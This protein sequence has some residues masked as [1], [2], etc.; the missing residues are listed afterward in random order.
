MTAISA[1]VNSARPQVLLDIDRGTG[2]GDLWL[3]RSDAAGSRPVR[4]YAELDTTAQTF[5]LVDYEPALGI[6]EYSLNTRDATGFTGAGSTTTVDVT[7]AGHVLPTFSLPF[8][9]SMLATVPSV[10]RWEGPRAAP[11]DVHDLIG[12]R[13]PLVG[14]RPLS[15]RRGSMTALVYGWDGFRNLEALLELGEVVHY[16]E[17]DN[18]GMDTFMVIRELTP[19]QVTGRLWEVTIGYVEVA[20]PVGDRYQVDWRFGVLPANYA[21]YADLTANYATFGHLATGGTL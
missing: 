9:P 20:P 8:R 13:Y 4:L 19:V 16:R 2:A 12:E 14:L 17:A 6:V 3:W 11:I 1:S 5:Q 10:T 18:N 21:T 15:G 7:A